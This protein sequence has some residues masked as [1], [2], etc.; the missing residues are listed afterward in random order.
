MDTTADQPRSLSI[1]RNFDGDKMSLLIGAV[2]GIS[3]VPSITVNVIPHGTGRYP[4]VGDWQWG[5]DDGLTVTVSDLGD[6]RFNL[7]VAAHELTEALL[8]RRDGVTEAEVD[9]WELAHL[10]SEEPGEE[11][12]APYFTQH[13]EACAVERWLAWMMGVVW[14]EYEAAYERLD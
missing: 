1:W 14:E 7:L 11:A 5:K 6:H 3:A 13:A 10:E 9:S 8:C 12:G 4:T 2:L